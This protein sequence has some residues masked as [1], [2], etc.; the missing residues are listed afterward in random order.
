M[1]SKKVQKIEIKQSDLHPHI[2]SRMGQRGISLSEIEKTINEGK[3]SG[4]AKEGTFG[5]VFVFQYNNYWEGNFFQEKEVSV[6]YK[7]KN[8]SLV[9]LTTKARYGKDF[10]KERQK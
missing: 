5:K 7:L 3:D 2:K 10:F 8:D 4:D 6:Y 9:L 1:K